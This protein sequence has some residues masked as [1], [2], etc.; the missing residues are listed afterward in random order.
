MQREQIRFAI[1]FVLLGF[2]IL[3]GKV[4]AEDAVDRRDKL[5]Q[6][7]GYNDDEID[8][9]M[10]TIAPTMSS[11]VFDTMV[12]RLAIKR[13]S[14]KPQNIEDERSTAMES[15][16]RNLQSLQ[17]AK[18]H[19]RSSRM[20]TKGYRESNGPIRI[21]K[22]RSHFRGYFIGMGVGGFRTLP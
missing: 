10:A 7:L 6:K 18:Q 19:A 17:Q 3:N 5:R 4:F 14:R 12:D 16:Y 8:Q 22:W 21:Y 11:D 15:H 9:F 13:T 20:A 2:I 1:V